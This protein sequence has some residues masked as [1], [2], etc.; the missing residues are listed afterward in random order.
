M[1]IPVS[2]EEV[3]V[4]RA[5]P[6]KKLWETIGNPR[7]LVMAQYRMGFELTPQGDL[8]LMRVFVDYSLPTTAPGWSGS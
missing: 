3:V 5:V 1:G 2:L 7:L 6:C 8:S 4:E